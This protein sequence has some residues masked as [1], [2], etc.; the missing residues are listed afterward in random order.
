MSRKKSAKL[1][2]LID[3]APCA[4][5]SI[6][7]W[8]LKKVLFSI[9]K[10]LSLA[11]SPWLLISSERP[12]S[13]LPAQVYW[14]YQVIHS[15]LPSFQEKRD[16]RELSFDSMNVLQVELLEI[17]SKLSEIPE[18]HQTIHS[19][20]R[21]EYV[22]L[23]TKNACLEFNWKSIIIVENE[24]FGLL[25]PIKR[26]K[27]RNSE[28]FLFLFSSCSVIDTG[29]SQDQQELFNYVQDQYLE[30]ILS[31]KKIGFTWLYENDWFKH[32][33]GDEKTSNKDG[34]RL[35]SRIV[36]QIGGTLLFL[37]ETLMTPPRTPLQTIVHEGKRSFLSLHV[38]S[39]CISVEASPMG[40]VD[41]LLGWTHSRNHS[42]LS[43]NTPNSTLDLELSGLYRKDPSWLDLR[44][45]GTV[46]WLITQSETA[47][48]E[49]FCFL[50][51]L[52]ETANHS[53]VAI[54]YCTKGSPENIVVTY[55]IE[56]FMSCMAIMFEVDN[57]IVDHLHRDIFYDSNSFT[58]SPLHTKTIAKSFEQVFYIYSSLF[59]SKSNNRLCEWYCFGE[60]HET[61]S[62][63]WKQ[64]ILS[65]ENMIQE[66]A[67]ELDRLLKD[68]ENTCLLSPTS[69]S[70]FAIEDSTCVSEKTPEFCGTLSFVTICQK[71]LVGAKTTEE[72]Q[73]ISSYALKS[74]TNLHEENKQQAIL[75]IQSQLLSIA[76]AKQN[77]ASND[78]EKDSKEHFYNDS[79]A[80]SNSESEWTKQWVQLIANIAIAILE[81][82]DPSSKNKVREMERSIIAL[83]EL[84]DDYNQLSE[85]RRMLQ[86]I[87]LEHLNN[88]L[89]QTGSYLLSSFD[90]DEGSCE[91]QKTPPKR[92]GLTKDISILHEVSELPEILGTIPHV[93][94]KRV[95]SGDVTPRTKAFLSGDSG[96][97]YDREPS[98]T[99]LKTKLTQERKMRGSSR[100]SSIRHM[101][102]INYRET[103][104]KEVH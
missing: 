54:F 69:Y 86:C 52:D 57:S 20:E 13:K 104:S 3:L 87:I 23:C 84:S 101:K 4:E 73:E 17:L 27:D 66:E 39:R 68:N 1:V 14:G 8:Y 45:R 89:P 2:F 97:V 31:Q 48:E 59:C 29:D 22:L 55:V 19:K 40:F 64:Q 100:T 81:G 99:K 15:N 95:L 5:V 32:L 33:K 47:S 34:T 80:T 42:L 26:K 102:T 9:C 60:D 74:L 38:S 11:K 35:L 85:A 18:K 61:S 21:L 41:T 76:D 94:G 16:F 12:D 6:E 96:F 79:T 56:P 72:V 49:S 58:F 77:K 50:S 30:D 43:S 65:V 70:K 67:T 37:D 24:P 103:K 93:Q 7:D 91:Q 98:I 28:N 44:K 71:L 62:T 92:K 78:K 25:S 10:I 53:L 46:P 63:H 88:C 75:D 90:L 51:W 82:Q 36:D 83:Q